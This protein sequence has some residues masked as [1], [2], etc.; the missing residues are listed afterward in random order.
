MSTS[1]PFTYKS[2]TPL[3]QRVDQFEKTA[4]YMMK[5]LD[6]TLQNIQTC[7][8][9]VSVVEHMKLS[10]APDAALILSQG[11]TLILE[12]HGKD[13]TLTQ[14][15]LAIQKELRDKYKDVQNSNTT[16]N[17]NLLE[18]NHNMDP[19]N[20]YS[21]KEKVFADKKFPVDLLRSTPT[22]AIKL[23]DL[24]SKVLKRV[25]DLIAKPIDLSS[26]DELTKRILDIGVS[27]IVNLFFLSFCC[28]LQRSYKYFWFV[29]VSFIFSQSSGNSSPIGKCLRDDR[30]KIV[31]FSRL[32]EFPVF[33]SRSVFFQPRS[34]SH[35]K[36]RSFR[37]EF[38]CY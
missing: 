16:T 37:E 14:R 29:S 4:R 3:D 11:D 38:R 28:V 33:I 17:I 31:F 22:S 27:Q 18:K 26:D 13:Q 24:V 12:T 21:P 30:E 36:S 6:Q 1:S 5:K 34:R 23:E 7:N 19:E 20:Q 9:G 32:N 25:N 8:D 10:I 15:L 2:M 35:F